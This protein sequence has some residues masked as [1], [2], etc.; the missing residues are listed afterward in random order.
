MNPLCSKITIYTIDAE[1]L[2]PLQ[3]TFAAQPL[4]SLHNISFLMQRPDLLAQAMIKL[5]KKHRRVCADEAKLH[6]DCF[7][8]TALHPRTITATLLRFDMAIERN[9]F[10]SARLATVLFSFFP[11]LRQMPQ[12][13]SLYRCQAANFSQISRQTEDAEWTSPPFLVAC[14]YVTDEYH[15]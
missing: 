11:F 7:S 10:C 8:V 5:S 12:L 15:V 2:L 13:Q 9:K 14:N 6:D 4:F 1:K 3:R